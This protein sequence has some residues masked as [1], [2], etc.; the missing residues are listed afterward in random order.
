MDSWS[1]M[2]IM[3]SVKFSRL[4]SYVVRILSQNGFMQTIIRLF[5][6]APRASSD[7]LFHCRDAE[8]R[9]ASGIK[10]T[11]D[12][13]PAVNL[14]SVNNDEIQGGLQD[15]YHRRTNQ[16]MRLSNGYLLKM[17]TGNGA[18]DSLSENISHIVSLR[19]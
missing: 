2:K 11:A 17:Y 14:I 5:E 4:G 6:V 19:K 9:V 15:R 13:Q 1:K 8:E 10:R 7:S 18:R 3:S 12:S 16:L